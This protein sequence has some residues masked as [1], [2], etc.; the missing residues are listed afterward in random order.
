MAFEKTLL[1]EYE[2]LKTHCRSYARKIEEEFS[3]DTYDSL[4]SGLFE[5]G[6][7]LT[8]LNIITPMLMTM[9]HKGL[10]K[11]LKKAGLDYDFLDFRKDFPQLRDYEP[12]PLL[13][14]IKEGIEALSPGVRAECVLYGCH[15]G[16]PGS[17]GD[18]QEDRS[19]HGALRSSQR[20]RH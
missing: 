19:F 1:R 7:R 13:Q 16:N 12:L 2:P 4:F 18:L 17:R 20:E 5:T 15:E 3:I 9:Y 6:R 14:E 8:Y 10:R 11:K